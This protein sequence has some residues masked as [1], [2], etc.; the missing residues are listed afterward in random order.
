MLTKELITKIAAE[1][2]M[3]KKQVEELMDTTCAVMLESLCA[4]KTIQ[5]MGFG[6]L[7]PKKRAP[8]LVVHPKTGERTMTPEK[9]QIVLHPANA[10][11]DEL[12]NI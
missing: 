4:G 7:E 9:T 5:L 11:K 12:K 1:T 6:T 10:L 3:T 8:R 2:G